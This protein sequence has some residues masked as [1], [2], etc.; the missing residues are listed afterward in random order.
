MD[1]QHYRE[2]TAYYDARVQGKVLD[3]VNKNPR[4][5]AAVATLAEWAPAKPTR[6]LEIGCGI[7]ATTWRMA[8]AWPHAEVIGADVSPLSIKTARSCFHRVNLAYVEGMIE[9]GALKGKF[10]LVVLMDVYE[11]VP[12]SERPSL[13]AVL[14]SLL[15]EESRVFLSFPTPTLQNFGRL[16]D[17]S[18]MQ[19]IDE[20]VRPGDMLALAA[21]TH[22]RLMYFREVGIWRYGDYAHAVLGRYRELAEV[23]RRKPR[24]KGLT[25]VKTAIKNV[26]RSSVGSEG[27]TNYLGFD[28]PGNPRPKSAPSFRVTS[29]QRRRLI[30]AALQSHAGQRPQ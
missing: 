11:H 23:A 19:P 2:V 30:K 14:D 1:P 7:G 20:D 26:L 21:A 22:T 5:E 8:R 13:H 15:S 12:L 16:H 10:D 9:P 28:F 3:F 18:G 17:A 4:I 27:R 6:I 29:A 25:H 24:P